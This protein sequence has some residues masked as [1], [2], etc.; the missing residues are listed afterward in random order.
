MYRGHQYKLLD[1][2]EIAAFAAS[3]IISN[4]G[5]K[6]VSERKLFDRR[7]VE[8]ELFKKAKRV[9]DVRERYKRMKQVIRE[10]EVGRSGDGGKG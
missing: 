3:R 2:Y 4:L 7:E 10:R 5:G 6:R 9:S 1:Y 8:R